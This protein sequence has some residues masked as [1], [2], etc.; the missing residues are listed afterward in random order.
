MS[1][2]TMLADEMSLCYSGIPAIDFYMEYAESLLRKQDALINE[3]FGALRQT[4]NAL[5]VATT[6]IRKDRIEVIEAIAAAD[7]VLAARKA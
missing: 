2:A 1:E 6:P 5:D 3:I 7:A 4:R